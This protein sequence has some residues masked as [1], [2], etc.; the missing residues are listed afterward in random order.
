MASEQGGA[1]IRNIAEVPWREFPNHFGG[2]LSKP[3]VMPET[4]GSK[5]IDYRISMYQPMAHVA[6]HKHAVQEQVYHVLKGE[7]LME[8]GNTRQVVRKHDV[9]FLPPG[10]EHSIANSGLVDLVFLVVTSPVTDDEGPV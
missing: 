1:I 2:A 4:A 5:H 6:K 9:I 8:I 7:G 10:V 3:L